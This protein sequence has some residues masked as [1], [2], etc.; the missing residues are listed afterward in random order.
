MANI[1]N[2]LS[3]WLYKWLLWLVLIKNGITSLEDILINH[4]Q[5]EKRLT[6]NTQENL[7]WPFGA[8]DGNNCEK[9]KRKRKL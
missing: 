9:T 3:V 4:F 1:S 5:E 8:G 2:S 6:L 7:L